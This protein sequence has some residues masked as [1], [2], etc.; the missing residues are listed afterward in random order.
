MEYPI[1]KIGITVSAVSENLSIYSP[2]FAK[3][4]RAEQD[5]MDLILRK[6]KM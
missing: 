1:Q 4:S 3:T 5:G 2:S 6:R